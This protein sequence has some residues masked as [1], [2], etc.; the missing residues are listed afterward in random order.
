MPKRRLYVLLS[1]SVV[2][3]TMIVLLLR[4]FA[5][6]KWT[7]ETDPRRLRL[8]AEYLD[9][10]RNAAAPPEPDT[11]SADSLGAMQS[12]SPNVVLILADDLARTDISLFGGRVETPNIDRIGTE[13]VT[14]TQATSTTSIC[15]PSRAALLTGRYQQRYGFELQP[16][17]RYARNLLEYLAFRYIID[18]GHMV[19]VA[20]RAVPRRRDL[21]DQGIPASEITLPE[22]LKARGYRTAAYGK[23]HLGYA[24]NFSPLRFGFEEHFGFYEAFSLYAPIDDDAV[25]DTPIDDFSDKHMWSRG[26]AQASA[27]V[28]NDV[29][30][31]ET[32]YLTFKFAELAVQ[33]IESRVESASASAASQGDRGGESRSEPF[34][35][36]LPFNAPHTPLQAPREYVDRFASEPD[37]IRRTYYA[38]IAALDD[39]VGEIV[40]AVDKAGIGDDTI[41]IF[42]SDNG[43]ASY[44]GM[45]DNEPYAGGK[46]TTFDGG[47]AVPLMIRYPRALEPG[48][49]FDAPVSLMDIYATVDAATDRTDASATDRSY[50]PPRP[51]GFDLDGVDLVPYLRGVIDGE[52]HEALY[53]R[54]IYNHAIRSGGWKLV[55][56][57]ADSLSGRAEVFLYH[58]AADP[59]ER[60][61]VASANP[62]VVS[63]LSDMLSS[64]EDTLA[65]PLWPPVMH[66]K[67]DVW[68]RRFWF[69]I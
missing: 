31:E 64:W 38:M 7:I 28:H 54:S 49:V 35:L 16:H 30:V 51:A 12:G 14:F 47:L 13:G 66:F 25:V 36:Y 33:Y 3:A 61:D 32:E 20:N 46:F 55:R 11:A 48:V 18:T 42:A 50:A 45:T 60:D 27:I 41:I 44:L 57:D 23:W 9:A 6:R 68:G 19:P 1:L 37:P 15:A 22:L 29:I 56:N 65:D 59:S 53:Y 24:E 2:L 39:A 62:E 5:D 34:F 21:L 52:P 4:P 17:D 67:L 8:K 43:G 58:I 69:A 10:V 63:R 26:R 40:D